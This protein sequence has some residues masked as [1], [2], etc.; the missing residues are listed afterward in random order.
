[1]VRIFNRVSL[2]LLWS[3]AESDYKV[4]QILRIGNE[5]GHAAAPNWIASEDSMAN[6]PGHSN[7]TVIGKSTRNLPLLVI[8]GSVLTE[9]S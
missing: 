3:S 4:L 8:Y 2:N 5:N 1:M 7:G 6:G 9:C